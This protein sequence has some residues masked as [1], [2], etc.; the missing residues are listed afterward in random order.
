MHVH[1][2]KWQI[3]TWLCCRSVPY[4]NGIFMKTSFSSVW[5]A[6]SCFVSSCFVSH[7]LSTVE[8]RKSISVDIF[9]IIGNQFGDRAEGAFPLTK[10]HYVGS[11]E[12]TSFNIR[13]L[14]GCL[15]LWMGFVHSLPNSQTF[16]FFCSTV[17][18][19]QIKN[20]M[21]VLP[22]QVGE[23]GAFPIWD[24]AK[25]GKSRFRKWQFGSFRRPEIVPG[26]IL[27]WSGVVRRFWGEV[28]SVSWDSNF[29][30]E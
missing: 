1:W 26:C 17:Q 13:D 18:R 10:N 5:I 6:S 15:E 19:A 21:S 27:S 29:G 3:Q 14:W 7:Q 22:R 11:R 4:V 2:K 30:T 28:T 20:F 16:F 23:P 9:C 12:S 8:R 24:R 25:I